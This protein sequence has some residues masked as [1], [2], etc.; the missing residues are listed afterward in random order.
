MWKRE[1]EPA[2]P[3]DPGRR[4]AV[5]ARSDRAERPIAPSPKRRSTARPRAPRAP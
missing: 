3:P 4:A 2:P 1:N 5:A